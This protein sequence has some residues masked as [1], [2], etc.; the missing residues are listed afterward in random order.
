MSNSLLT[1]ELAKRLT[2]AHPTAT[3]DEIAKKTAVFAAAYTSVGDQIIP[4]GD[5]RALQ[6]AAAASPQVAGALASAYVHGHGGPNATPM[7][8]VERRLK[9]MGM[10][11]NVFDGDG[12]DSKSFEDIDW[13]PKGA[14]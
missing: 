4:S 5:E 10:S 8:R 2:L 13:T 12:A 11:M 9:S 1:T 7:D 3:S 6:A 14:A